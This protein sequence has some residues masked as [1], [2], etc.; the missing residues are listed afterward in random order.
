MVC[1]AGEELTDPAED[2]KLRN[3]KRQS[4]G[5]Q[6]HAQESDRVTYYVA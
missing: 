4:S 6:T 5:E 1:R 3:I 2:R